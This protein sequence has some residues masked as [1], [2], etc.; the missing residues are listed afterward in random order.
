MAYQREVYRAVEEQFAARRRENE[1][2][3]QR[4]KDEVYAKL[5][6]LRE[7]EREIAQ[8]SIALTRTILR[9]GPV[10]ETVKKIKESNMALRAERT[11]LLAELSLP[12]DY[13]DVKPHCRRCGDEGFVGG[14]MCGCFARELKKAAYE[15]SNLGGAL[16]DQSF[17]NFKLDYY[18]DEA[19]VTDGKLT[20][21]ELMSKNYETVKKFAEGFDTDRM[22]GLLFFGGPG[23]GKTH[24]ST[25]V[26]RELI[27]SGHSVVYETAPDIFAKYERER[28]GRLDQPGDL[29]QYEQTDLLIVDD[30]GTEFSSPFVQS[31]F[32]S[33][34]NSRMIH[35]RKTIVSTN[36]ALKDLSVR[37]GEKIISRI[38]GE[39]GML[40]FVGTDVRAQKRRGQTRR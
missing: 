14:R 10:K 36:L 12:Y 8:T 3:R 4:R 31:V 21:R 17:K 39:F 20:E 23:L 1:S 32:F 26:A 22:L 16:R 34:V 28:F 27:D 30:L 33:L 5:P 19:K 13:L 18:S 6:R 7:I 40:H 24:L 35:G 15:M 29:D 37:Y 2:E 25:A 38:F 11:E 9:G